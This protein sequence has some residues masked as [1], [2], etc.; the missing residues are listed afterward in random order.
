[1]KTIEA[2]FF[3]AGITL[4]RLITNSE[5]CNCKTTAT[6]EDVIDY[7]VVFCNIVTAK[8]SSLIKSLNNTMNEASNPNSNNNGTLTLSG[9]EYGQ[10]TKL[11]LISDSVL[12]FRLPVNNDPA[13][14]LFTPI[15][16]LFRNLGTI[17][18]LRLFASL[19]SERRI[20]F[21]ST[22]LQR[23]SS[24]VHASIALLSIANLSWQHIFIPIL[25]YDLLSYVCAPMPFVIGI[26]SC[27]LKYLDYNTLGE[28][29]IVD[30][31]NAE[32]QLQ[33]VNSIPLEHFSPDLLAEEENA[34]I[35]RERETED[36]A[37][38]I[39]Q[40]EIDSIMKTDKKIREGGEATGLM[41]AA[42]ITAGIL[43]NSA[44]KAKDLSKGFIGFL[45]KKLKDAGANKNTQNIITAV[46]DG[47]HFGEQDNE[48]D[49]GRNVG[50]FRDSYSASTSS[51]TPNDGIPSGESNNNNNNDTNPS[52][53]R[54]DESV[55]FDN[56]PG[57]TAI[58]TSFLSFY[59]YFIGDYRTYIT[60]DASGAMIGDRTGF[61]SRRRAFGD[62]G[63]M[64]KCFE[65]FSKSQMFEQFSDER[66]TK[67]NSLSNMEREGRS[68]EL[69]LGG[70]SEILMSQRTPFTCSEIR[71]VI[72]MLSP[73]PIKNADVNKQLAM[74][75]TSNTAFRG[76]YEK[77]LTQLALVCNDL[78]TN[79]R[80]VMD[81]CWMRLKDSKGLRWR[82]AQLSLQIIKQLLLDGPLTVV[83]E[84]MDNID[85]IR[86]F[87]TYTGI[88]S[89][90]GQAPTKIV[91]TAAKDVFS[92]LTDI[93][94]LSTERKARVFFRCNSSKYSA[95]LM[96]N[97]NC[98][99]YSQVCWGKEKKV[100][101]RFVDLNAMMKPPQHRLRKNDGKNGT[102]PIIEKSFVDDNALTLPRS[103]SG[104]VRSLRAVSSGENHAAPAHDAPPASGFIDLLDFNGGG[105]SFGGSDPFINS[106]EQN[107]PQTQQ[108]QQKPS[109]DPFSDGFGFDSQPSSKQETKQTPFGGEEW[110][111]DSVPTSKT[112][113]SAAFP[114]M[115]G[116]SEKELLSV[117]PQP[118]RTS[119]AFPSNVVQVEFPPKTTSTLKFSNFPSSDGSAPLDFSKAAKEQQQQQ[120]QQQKPTV[121]EESDPWGDDGFSSDPFAVSES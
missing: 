89:I 83:V 100:G 74:S 22:S 25:P 60:R 82:H 23:L 10:N 107:Q 61:I 16:P 77:T 7:D 17:T 54:E 104:P 58:R 12:R 15:L 108:Q 106:D 80:N 56:L 121:T 9:L 37:A 59:I 105:L 78:Q 34:F 45:G 2:I 11:S 113:A 13:S 115:A 73:N 30:C 43:N 93:G 69:T 67:L 118:V 47:L 103:G 64:L 88:M 87:L 24:T 91:R 27:H 53:L 99:K 6:E 41:G 49:G 18:S 52:T 119:A 109:W 44:N 50:N 46:S 90:G 102:V 33:N 40:S 35:Q 32:L 75:L 55:T 8:I 26:L 4:S 96:R 81:V 97:P 62:R 57:E 116:I 98:T 31:D 14:K 48:D 117:K 72:K 86:G 120:Q 84:I 28:L 95:N 70:C 79:L 85:V 63:G 21:T 36:T 92:Y 39:L 51:S 111:F 71:K 101:T 94:R 114:S 65:A 110:D 76:D 42:G 68:G 20:L 66:A 5:N 29:M 3:W 19:L 38:D 1:M 112:T